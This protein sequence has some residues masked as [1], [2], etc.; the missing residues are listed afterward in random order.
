MTDMQNKK[1]I[2]GNKD[3]FKTLY[4]EKR[5]QLVIDIIKQHVVEINES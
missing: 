1:T 4:F 5:I 2:Q 3:C